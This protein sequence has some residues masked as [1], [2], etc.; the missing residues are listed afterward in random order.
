[1]IQRCLLANQLRRT[2]NGSL[3]LKDL[4]TVF[5]PGGQATFSGPGDRPQR[6]EG[7][8]LIP[9]GLMAKLPGRTVEGSLNLKDLLT[10]LPASGQ[11]TFS[12]SVERPKRGAAYLLIPQ[13]LMA[14][15]LRRTEGSLLNLKDL[16]AV[17][18]RWLKG[19]FE[20]ESVLRPLFCVESH[21]IPP[22]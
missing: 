18:S 10:I 12:G 21:Q 9:Q 7:N 13:G 6:G 15:L 4:L 5:P 16:A 2:S 8:L 17:F 14:R 19:L 3:N 22:F 11:A 1:L 20:N